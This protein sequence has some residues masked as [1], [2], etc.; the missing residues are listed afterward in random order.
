MS[1]D[2]LID[3]PRQRAQGQLAGITSVCSAHPVV[4]RA[5]LRHGLDHDAPVLIEATCNQV[6]QD[7]GYT[8]MTP[9]DFRAFVETIADAVGFP[10]QRLLLGGDHLGPNPWKGLPAEEALTKSEV[11]IAAF[12]RAGFSKIHID[13]SMGCSGESVALDDHETAT[14]AVRLARAAEAAR[15]PGNPAPVYIIGT[16]VPIP[17][18]AT[19]ALDHIEVTDAAAAKQTV[20]I[21]RA[22][23]AAAGLGDA[24][25]RVIGLVVQPGVEFG[26]DSVMIYEPDAARALSASLPQLPG[27]VFEAHSTDYQPVTSLL[28][29]VRDGFAI[30]KVGPELTFALRQALYGLDHIAREL[31]L[32]DSSL[33]DIVEKVM[34]AEPKNWKHY[35]SGDELA[36]HFQRHYSLSDR[37][38]YYW[39]EPEI[40]AAVERLLAALAES[41][42]PPPLIHQYLPFACNADDGL[43]VSRTAHDLLEQSVICVLERYRRA[44]IGM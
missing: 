44:I 1:T 38:R 37:I 41:K 11:M 3:L 35:Y 16:E 12:V 21:H 9:A 10:K 34:L 19:E 39:P 33:K 24:F 7:G 23:F 25:S 4:I 6:N 17:G 40:S 31:G 26:H 2:F 14:R 15:L 5:A 27:F 43:P 18:G 32:L 30:L 42:I 8:G 29:L 28:A 20:E 13:T 22:A 36:L